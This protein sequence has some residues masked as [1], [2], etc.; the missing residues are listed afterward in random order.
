MKI[1]ILIC[2]VLVSAIIGQAVATTTTVSIVDTNGAK[3]DKVSIPV[4]MTGAK[5]LGALGL[6]LKYDSSV[7]KT[8]GSENGKMT[9]NAMIASNEIV[10]GAVH[11]SLIDTKGVS[12]DGILLTTTFEVVGNAGSSTKISMEATGYDI[13]LLDAPMQTSSGTF[14]VEEQGFPILTLLIIAVIAIVAFLWYKK[15]KETEK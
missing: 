2:I 6:T 9:T 4:H 11:I 8:V 7:L 10:P 12:G 1:E 5:N 14:K 3:G 15:S 13:D